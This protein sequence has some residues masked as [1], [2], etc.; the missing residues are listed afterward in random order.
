MRWQ[1][2]AIDDYGNVRRATAPTQLPG[3]AWFWSMQADA[4]SSS[5]RTI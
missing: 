5:H 2:K 4:P 1:H 3:V